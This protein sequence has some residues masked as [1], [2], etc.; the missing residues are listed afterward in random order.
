MH[1]LLVCPTFGRLAAEKTEHRLNWLDFTRATIFY[2]PDFAN[3][4]N[5]ELQERKS[6]ELAETFAK[7]WFYEKT[8]LPEKNEPGK[9]ART[10]LDETFAENPEANFRNLTLQKIT[11]AI[12]TDFA[13]WNRLFA[14]T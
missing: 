12:K 7:N 1:A 11:F 13:K 8:T 3:G 5:F 6:W 14:K 9:K 2:K 4:I 10:K